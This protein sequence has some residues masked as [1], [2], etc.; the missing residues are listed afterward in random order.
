[1]AQMKIDWILSS[2]DQRCLYYSLCCKNIEEEE[3]S[4]GGGDKK[5]V[6]VVEVL[7]LLKV[8]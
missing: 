6:L 4:G 7:S 8:Y 2:I 1:M 3:G 5:I